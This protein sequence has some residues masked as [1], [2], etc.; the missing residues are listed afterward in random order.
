M[1][2][3]R[4][5]R[6]VSEGL[7]RPTPRPDG[8]QALDHTIAALVELDA[9]GLCQQWRHC[10]GGTPPAHLPHWRLMK[11]LAYRI[12]AAALGPLGNETLRILR[13]PK[14]ETLASSDGHPFK[15]RIGATRAGAKLKAGALLAR[16]WNGRFERL[17]VLDKGFAWNGETYGSLSQVAKALTGTSW[18]GHRFFRL[19]TASSDRSAM[20]RRRSGVCDAGSPNAASMPIKDSRGVSASASS[21]LLKKSVGR[22]LEFLLGS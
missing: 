11:I 3:R 21:R 2:E 5:S 12:Q 13:Q 8:V 1:A 15:A 18:T 4:P 19:R 14:G 22:A 10:L 9:N 20:V 7:P 17:M 16:E 6:G